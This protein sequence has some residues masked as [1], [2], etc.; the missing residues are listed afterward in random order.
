MAFAINT[1]D[2]RI[3]VWVEG[4]SNCQYHPIPDDIALGV[5]DGSIKAE[6]V[7]NAINRKRYMDKDFDWTALRQAEDQLNVRT[8]KF[9]FEE[10]PLEVSKEQTDEVK[11]AITMKDV[12]EGESAKEDGDMIANADVIANAI[13]GKKITHAKA[14]K[15]YDSL[16]IFAESA[17]T[18]EGKA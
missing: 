9:D 11:N 8:A 17:P 18:I 4:V 6:A 16:G 12:V 2:G 15:K 5:R 3:S 7:I 13:E 10:K 14:Q 1:K